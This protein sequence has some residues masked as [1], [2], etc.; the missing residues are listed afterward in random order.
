MTI[1]DAKF[2]SIFRR[3]IYKGRTK[4]K[5]VSEYIYAGETYYKAHLTKYKWCR[6]FSSIRDAAIAVDKLLMQHNRNPLNI[7]KKKI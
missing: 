6:Y 7:F 4:Y 2:K 5:Y 3:G 1:I